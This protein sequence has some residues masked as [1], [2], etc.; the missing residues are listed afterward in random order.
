[1]ADNRRSLRPI[2]GADRPKRRR[3]N[4]RGE[5]LLALL[6]TVVVLAVLALLEVFSRQRLLFASLASSAF[7]IYLDPEHGTNT[8]R[9][10][11][12]SHLIASLSG[13]LIYLALG[14]GYVSGGI[15]MIITIVAMIVLDSVHPPAVS[16]ALSFA[17][18]DDFVKTLALF[19]MALGLIAVLVVLQRSALWLVSR[20]RETTT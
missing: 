9:S 1:M 15:A 16:T 6:P 2:P 12:L 18:R 11:L 4:L 17:F 5:F 19:I 20:L 14:A 3:L 10:L 7:L 8:T 13:A